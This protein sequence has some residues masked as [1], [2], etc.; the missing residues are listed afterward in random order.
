M[1]TADVINEIENRISEFC[2]KSEWW[3]I[4][5]EEIVEI[6]GKASN[7]FER[8]INSLIERGIIVIDKPPGPT[9]HEVVAWVKRMLGVKKVG[10]GGT[11]EGLL[12][13]DPGETPKSQVS[14]LLD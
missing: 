8:D 14:C 12:D 6:E 9:S 11:L 10:H 7:P 1:K 13:G 2:G 3:N 5:A 4:L